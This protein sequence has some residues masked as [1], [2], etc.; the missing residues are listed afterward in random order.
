MKLVASLVMLVVA[1]AAC[2]GDHKTPPAPGSGS[3]IAS[4]AAPTPPPANATPD[5][6]EAG[7]RAIERASCKSPEAAKFLD[8]ARQTLAGTL[9]VARKASS[10]DP[11]QLQI[12]CAQL[13]Q[14][15]LR[16]ASTSGCTIELGDVDRK[17]ITSLLEAWYAE[18][19]PVVPTGD[20]ASDALI[21]RIVAVR[22]AMCACTDMTCLARVDKQIDTIGALAAGAPQ[23]ARDLGTKLLDDVSRCEARIR[24]GKP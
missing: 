1:L 5:V 24:N 12:V 7:V 9:D 10:A 3:A 23:V 15:L 19:T 16:D 17:Q 14:A 4:G 18:R 8:R 22:D 11:H 2:K 20:S 6:C 21:A 13:V